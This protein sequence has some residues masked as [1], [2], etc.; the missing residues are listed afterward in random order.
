MGKG[1]V[2][3]LKS[4]KD[5]TTDEQREIAKKGGK[6]SGQ[7]RRERKLLSQI[8]A[9]IIDKKATTI[10]EA[11]ENKLN[12]GDISFLPEMGKLTEGSKVNLDASIM[13]DT[14]FKIVKK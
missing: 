8:Y 5:R 11:I 7:V 4:L 13:S 12:K 6:K 2:E 14:Q 3:N 10:Q 9:E 1:R